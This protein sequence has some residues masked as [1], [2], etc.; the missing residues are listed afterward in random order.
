METMGFAQTF[1]IGEPKAP[2]SPLP[3]YQTNNTCLFGNSNSRVYAD[4]MLKTHLTE[5]DSFLKGY[6]KEIEK[7]LIPDYIRETNFKPYIKKDLVLCAMKRI[8]MVSQT[9]KSCSTSNETGKFQK[10]TPCVTD[11]VVDYIYWGLN[12][13]MRCFGNQLDNE[14]RKMIFKKLNH[15]S[16]FGF[17]FQYTGGTG[18][19]QLIGESQK[20]MFLPGHAGF[21]FL[22]S[23]MN[24]NKNSCE[25]F[26][27]LINRSKK[28][29]SLKSCEFISIGDGIGRSLIGGIGLYL[30]YRSDPANP[31]SAENL[32]DY[33]GLPRS[34][35]AEYKKIRSYITLGMYNR[36]PGAVLASSKHRIGRGAL[37]K[38][39]PAE[40]YKIVMSLIKNSNFNGYVRA[41]ETSTNKIF[42]SS[43]TCKI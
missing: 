40:A 3:S 38:K 29:K 27:Q 42:D 41:V 23:H 22:N 8:P 31:Y 36:G 21:S 37:A 43:G 9:K 33:W 12:E 1:L 25:N 17:F 10:Q 5:Q 20:D 11:Q 39:T 15:E 26:I 19:A 32:L 18:I 6:K 34:D 14:E 28:S 13:T 16:A 35:S 4:Q 30:H 7:N 2:S 24:R